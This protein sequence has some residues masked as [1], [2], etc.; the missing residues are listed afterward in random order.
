MTHRYSVVAALFVLSLITYI[1]RVAISSAKDAVAL[2]LHL[3]DTQ[4]GLVFS[5]FSLGYALAQVPGGWL[6]DRWGPRLA[7][8]AVVT[9]WSALTAFTGAAWSLVSLVVIRFL[10]GIAEAG[11]FPGTARAFVN[12]LPIA[13]RGRANGLFFSGSRFGGAAAFPLIVWLLSISNWR[14]AFLLLGVG[15]LLWAAFW[16]L[17]FTDYPKDSHHVPVAPAHSE[18]RLK[19]VFTTTRFLPAMGQYFAGNFTFFICLSWLSPYL[20]KTYSLSD[21]ETASLSMI[22]LLV[23]ATSLWFSGW[24]VDRL[25]RN[26][27]LRPWSRRLPG[28]IGFALAAACMV[29]G[30]SATS[31]WQA[32][33][34][35]TLATFG[36]DM[37][38]SPSWSYCADIAGKNAGSVSAAMNMVGNIGSFLSANAFPWLIAWTGSAETYFLVSRSPKPMQRRTLAANEIA[39]R[40]WRD[41]I[42]L[43]LFRFVLLPQFLD[44]ATPSP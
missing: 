29:A 40:G 2:D 26:P 14:V 32:I 42:V 35:F 44:E 1:D 20:K 21:S 18:M 31:A 16:F 7:L 22:P 12:W 3:S 34:W 17:R 11:A 24:L 27:R 6:A 36:V 33:G 28:M 9:V 30:S 38:I 10:F 15:G 13:E 23:G 39:F 19:E 25:F 37:T 41:S 5:A 8:A 43:E 4:M